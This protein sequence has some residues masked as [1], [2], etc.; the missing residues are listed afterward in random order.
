MREAHVAGML[1]GLLASTSAF[2]M[3]WHI[4]LADAENF[5]AYEREMQPLPEGVMSQSNLLTPIAYRRN[6]R[7]ETPEGQGL[8]VPADLLRPEVIESTMATGARMYD[9]YCTP[10]HGDGVNLGAVAAPGRYPA[11]A[12]LA[13]PTGR[14]QN[15]TDG[16]V[17]LT[18]RN[19]GG[20]M[21]GYGWAM[22]D[23]ELWSVTAWMR[24]EFAEGRKPMP[25]EPEPAEPVEPAEGEESQP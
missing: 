21:P 3:P 6:F 1:L 11:V 23:Q 19:G 16:H 24:Q 20:I 15:L 13:G 14:V 9:V 25:P 22:N 17:Y 18:L 5:K 10:C 12:V 7:R 4:D 2:A 8:M